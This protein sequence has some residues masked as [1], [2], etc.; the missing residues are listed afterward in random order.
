[1]L[2]DKD[3]ELC[4]KRMTEMAQIPLYQTEVLEKG[5]RALVDG[6]VPYL[7]S[8]GGTTPELRRHLNSLLENRD[9]VEKIVAGCFGLM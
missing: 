3:R 5:P 9:E 6:L 7:E 1:M 8:G 4:Q 2:S